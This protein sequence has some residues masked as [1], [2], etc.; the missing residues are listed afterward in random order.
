[1]RLVPD[2]GTRMLRGPAHWQAC[3]LHDT[4]LV[5][6]VV[7]LASDPAPVPPGLGNAPFTGGFAG[8][9][10]DPRCRLFHPRPEDGTIETV[11]W[12]RTSSL[13]VHDAAAT[14]FAIATPESGGALP[15]R[16][17][18]LACDDRAFLYVADPDA[19][20]VWLVD[21]WQQEVSRA[22]AFL[23]APLDVSACGGAVFV[24]LDDGST[25]QLAPC[26]EPRRMPWPVKAGADRLVVTTS[27]TGGWLAWV[28]QRA[29][30]VDAQLWALHLDRGLAAPFCTDVVAEREDP[31]L[32]TLVTLAQRPGEEFLRMR[33]AGNQPAAQPSL[34]APNYDGRGIALAPDGRISYWTAKGLRQ[35]VPARLNYRPAGRVFGFALDS[36]FDQN[37]WGQVRIEACVPPGTQLRMAAFTRD[38]LDFADPIDGLGA[39]TTIPVL[40]QA[41]WAA[42]D[43]DDQ[44]LFRDPSQRPLSPAPADGFAFYDAP[45]VADLGRYLWLVFE[46]T[47]TRSKSPRLRAVDV[48]YPGHPLLQSLP[49]TLWREPAAQSFLFRLLMPMAAMLAEWRDVSATRHRLL[50][51]RISPTEALGWLAGF[52]GLVLDPCWTEAVQRRMIAQ[53]APL[54]RTRGTLA[55]LQAMLRTLTGAEVVILENFRLRGGGV[56]GNAQ[57]Q[58]S[59]AVL[60]FGYRIGG[61]IGEPGDAP[62]ADAPGV[63]FDDFAHRFSVTIV[64][65]LDDA[66]LACAR[67]LVEMHKPAHTDFTLCTACAGIRAGVGDH[68]G[69]STVVGKSAGFD[70]AILGDSALDQGYLLGRP[71]IQEGA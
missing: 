64:A 36:G 15:R 8:L 9:A 37:R 6:D 4:A 48:E 46:F 70:V 60:G 54:L 47:G 5:D 29:G 23:A 40:S 2:T 35:A 20:T 61:L 44:A 50:D 63:D 30:Q 41:T 49:R 24:L 43:G 1:M 17:L 39:G 21:T 65:A 52:V 58:A 28:L 34:S 31:D 25:W 22:I 45:V 12:A 13:G 59:Q 62:P 27:A 69:L 18:A 55:S 71:P 66:Q 56:V 53:A 57:A 32:G 16:P 19:S 51:A 38:A 10:F 14:P 3:A 26:D 68:V 11:L 67:R 42:F 7:M 33:L